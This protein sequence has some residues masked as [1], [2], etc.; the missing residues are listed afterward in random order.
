MDLNICMA[1]DDNYIQ[2]MGISIISIMENSFQD[3]NIHILNNDI[4]KNN[5]QNLKTIEKKYKHLKLIFYDIHEYFEKK[6]I[7]KIIS[8]ELRNND[9]YNLLGISAFSRLFLEDILPQDIDK[10]LYLDSDTIVLNSLS[11]LFNIDLYNY[12]VAGVIDIISNI[13]KYFYQGTKELKNPF[14]NSG[15]LLI[16]LK[17]WREIKF[18][19]QSISLIKEYDD[20]NFLHDQNIINIICN[21]NI[22]FLESKYNMMSEFYYVKYEK[23]LKMNKYFGSIN[24]FYSITQFN[25][26]LKNPVIVHFISQVWDRPWI[27]QIGLFNHKPKNPFNEKYNEYK[28]ISPWADEPLFKNNK[29][30]HEKIYY[31]CIRFIMMYF[32]PIILSILY[33]IKHEI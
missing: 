10:V 29:K 27:S 26:Y 12:Y 7:E 18:S 1:S 21:E 3:V 5:I 23:N 24:K 30:F 2:H 9:F 6:N 28:N 20:K 13:T 8:N 14:I 4:S 22:L 11:E 33:Y 32:P 25:N 17:K 19:K 31:E 16:N 15:V